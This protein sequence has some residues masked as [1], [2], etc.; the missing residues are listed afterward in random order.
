MSLSEISN[1]LIN[2]E[3]KI[4]YK[5]MESCPSGLKTNS[6][7]STK[8]LHYFTFLKIRVEAKNLISNDLTIIANLMKTT[9]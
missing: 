3:E 6:K 2:E 8:N 9:L 4:E 1:S 5:G 7:T